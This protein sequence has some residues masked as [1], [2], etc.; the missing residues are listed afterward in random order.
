MLT[1]TVSL[2]RSNALVILATARAQTVNG[3]TWIVALLSQRKRQ[4]KHSVSNH[5]CPGILLFPQWE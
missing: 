4:K 5:R 2:D 1:F 3:W